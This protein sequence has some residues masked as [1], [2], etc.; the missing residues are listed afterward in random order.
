[1]YKFISVAPRPHAR[2]DAIAALSA[3]PTLGIEITIPELAAACSLGNLDHH[4]ERSNERPA[5]EQA[6]TCVLPGPGA[7]IAILRADPDA[8]GAAAVL[9][10]RAEPPAGVDAS[11]LE[12]IRRIAA[13]D[14]F[15][16]GP[17]PGPRPLDDLSDVD[18]AFQ[19]LA[20]LVSNFRTP[21]EGRV[22]LMQGYLEHGTEKWDRECEIRDAI[23]AARAERLAAIE[24]SDIR[25]AGNIGVV[26]GTHRAAMGMGYRLAP[27]VVAT[28][29]EMPNQDGSTY[30]KHTIAQYNPIYYD[31]LALCD[32]LNIAEPGG[33]WGGNLESGIL[34]SPQGVSSALTTEQVVEIVQQFVW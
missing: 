6:L 20:R 21:L 28:N 32:A 24:T 17:W 15:E 10:S 11:M 8:I 23:D 7:Q 2:E 34:G 1:M 31:T 4:G 19:G 13:A 12:R 5:I 29:P 16:Y 26:V 18:W 22:A 30:L 14:V 27:V 3:M 9:V 33:G 25:T